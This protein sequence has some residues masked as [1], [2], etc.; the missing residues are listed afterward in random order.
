MEWKIGEWTIGKLGRRGIR[1]AGAP[2]V[3]DVPGHSGSP[4]A[5]IEDPVATATYCLLSN[6]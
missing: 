1:R 6:M 2:P 4:N 5:T 3:S